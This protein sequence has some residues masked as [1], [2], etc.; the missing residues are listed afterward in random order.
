MRSNLPPKSEEIPEK[1]LRSFDFRILDEKEAAEKLPQ[2]FPNFPQENNKNE[3]LRKLENEK[4]F[5]VHATVQ[6]N[7]EVN[8]YLYGI[9][10]N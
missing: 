2:N 9:Y 1:P 8:F 4:P 3:N 5:I 10:R 7:E 6:R